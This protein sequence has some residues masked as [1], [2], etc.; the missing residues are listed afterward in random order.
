MRVWNGKT[1]NEYS[2]CTRE[3]RKHYHRMR[4]VVA[5][6]VKQKKTKRVPKKKQ[7]KKRAGVAYLKKVASAERGANFYL[8]GEWKVLRYEVLKERGA[9]C[10]ACGV[11][12]ASGAT[13]HVDH[14][15]PRY[16]F[17]KLE[18]VK[19]NLQILCS[20][21]NEGKGA[22]DETDWRKE[23]VRLKKKRMES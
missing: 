5:D 10:E 2:F 12:A 8:S 3:C 14:I 21:C 18:L 22:W 6:V 7:E 17:P 11:T 20:V 23:N 13:L 19:E 9:R 4:D 15:K 16:R 1:I